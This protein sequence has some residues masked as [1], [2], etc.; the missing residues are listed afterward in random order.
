LTNIHLS[1]DIWTLLNKHLLLRV[2]GDFIDCIEEKHLKTLLGL[3][4][5]AGYSRDDQ[6]DALLPLL[7]DYDIVQKLGAV[8]GDNSSTNDTLCRAIEAY[9]KREEGDLQ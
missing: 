8:V 9:L 5:I 2:T 7:Q 1:L 6:F 3:R 4:P